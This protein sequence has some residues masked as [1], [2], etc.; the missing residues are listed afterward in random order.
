[1]IFV[2]LDFWDVGYG[3]RD[4]VCGKDIIPTHHKPLIGIHTSHPKFKEFSNIF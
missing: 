3:V 1:M 4:G 2:P